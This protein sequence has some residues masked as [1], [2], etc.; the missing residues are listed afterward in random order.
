MTSMSGTSLATLVCAAMLCAGCV[1]GDEE[2][3]RAPVPNSVPAPEP[4]PPPVLVPEPVQ[5]FITDPAFCPENGWG[6]IEQWQAQSMQ[7]TVPEE[8]EILTQVGMCA[9]NTGEWTYLRNNGHT[10]WDIE[11]PSVIEHHYYLNEPA[12]LLP[13]RQEGGA[14][15]TL[16]PRE[17]A[18]IHAAPAQVTWSIDVP[19]TLA[20]V[21]SSEM[22]Y[23]YDVERELTSE[24]LNLW[25]NNARTGSP[26][27]AFAVCTSSAYS[28]AAK[29]WSADT[30]VEAVLG[31]INAA[32]SAGGSAS[33]C[34]AAVTEWDDERRVASGL[35]PRTTPLLKSQT[36]QLAETRLGWATQASK[37]A[38]AIIK[39]SPRG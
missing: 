35:E 20:V 18:L 11:A 14:S 39:A 23:Q 27:K 3:P 30:D 36:F 38:T 26:N 37:W 25:K 9:S 19:M 12:V 17:V 5:T 24:A 7:T 13:L 33:G 16:G 4:D 31:D 6:G 2:P 34:L 28:I 1:G 22:A 32:L 15:T 21:T 10:A 29:E 8:A